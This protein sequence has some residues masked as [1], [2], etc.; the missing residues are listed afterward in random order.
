MSI[1]YG[2]GRIISCDYLCLCELV[3]VCERVRA[4]CACS[5]LH[6]HGSVRLRP[7]CAPS[8]RVC[9]SVR[10][11]CVAVY[12]GVSEAICVCVYVCEHSRACVFYAFMTCADESTAMCVCARVFSWVWKHLRVQMHDGVCEWMFVWARMYVYVCRAYVCACA[13]ECPYMWVFAC[14]FRFHWAFALLWEHICMLVRMVIRVRA[15]VRVGVNVRE[16]V[17]EAKCGRIVICVPV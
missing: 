5:R 16:C 7:N 14:V 12:V 3:P 9:V 6:A 17:S 10:T 2:H 13:D 11:V 1:Y 15:C 8:A 4:K